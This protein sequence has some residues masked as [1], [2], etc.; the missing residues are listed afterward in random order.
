VATFALVGAQSLPANAAI[1]Y[2]QCAN[3]NNF[4]CGHL[5]V[6][7]D[8]SGATPG[9]VTL[10][11]RRHRAALGEA[12]S[13]I[14][15]LAGGP[16]QPALPFAEE[17]AEL[18]GPI[19]ATRDLIVF[20]QRGIGLSD[21][22]AC[23]AFENSSVY[24]SE[25][26]LIAACAS[27]LGTARSFYTS[28]DTV[29][30]IEAIRVAGGYEKLV[31]YGTSYG[32]KVAEE[33]AQ[34]YPEHVEALVLDSVVPPNGPEPLDRATFAAV[35]RVLR[36]ICANHLCAHITREPVADL[37]KVV[38]KMHGGALR[39]RVLDGY[40][41]PHTV[42][43]TSNE[44]LG[45]L[46]QGDF[47]S[48]LR[49]E[50]VTDDRAAANG[51]V[52]P[53]ARLLVNTA[54]GEESPSEDNDSPLYFA[55]TCEE[56]TFPWNRAS[57]PK[58]RLAEAVRRIKSL[59]ASA[60]APFT[61]A[62]M[63][64]F[65][66]LEACASWPFTSPFPPVL[67][68]ALPNVPTLILSGAD[69][70]RTPTANAREV[71]AQISDA[72]LLVVPYTGHSVLG[73]EPTA[74]ASE[75]LQAL[76]AGKPIKPCAPA[77]PPATL[78]PPPLPPLALSQVPA[79][80]GTGGRPGRTLQAVVLTLDD[81]G[82]QVGWQLGSLSGSSLLKLTTLQSGGLRSGWVQYKEGA[83]TFHGY[84]FVPGVSITGKL[85]GAVVDLHVGGSA[86]AS[87]T[88][89]VGGAGSLMGTLGGRHVVYHLPKTTASVAIVG[90]D[91]RASHHLGPGGSAARAAAERLG[92]P[93]AG[94][95]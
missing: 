44:L 20:D 66:D 69:D 9:T 33:Y 81:F 78:R 52:A 36:Q 60:T 17:F 5:T 64:A 42:R 93:L 83:Y 13:A 26:A 11:L 22:L 74:C 59:G 48:R 89:H 73:E 95:I 51:D 71:A 57:K 39:G 3:T 7:L 15:A 4:A 8:P 54:S 2:K 88:L 18:L 90:E 31:L 72:H 65:S 94:L 62:N 53:L 70:L 37:A 34:E 79:A 61:P 28:A 91:A 67:A 56:Q 76:F 46:V 16:G 58:A 29:A 68:G 75:A 19:A 24:H 77:P 38:R 32:T 87:G 6:P 35:P 84:S 14:I 41:H 63:L 82:R 43:V 45:M 40:G 30:D 12:H 1:S 55:T 85:A 21:P 23:N 92:G 25:G 10:A 27:Q 50:F 80:P 86:A 47:S 49:A